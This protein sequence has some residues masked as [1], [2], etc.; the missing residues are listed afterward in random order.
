VRLPRSVD[1]RSVVAVARF[2]IVG[3]NPWPDRQSRIEAL[4]PCP[5]L[6]RPDY[7]KLYHYDPDDRER[8]SLG[9][10]PVLRPGERYRLTFV[11][12]AMASPNA[13]VARKQRGFSRVLVAVDP[14]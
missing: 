13:P 12:G 11:R 3:E 7:A 8:D 5:E 14:R 1:L 9:H 6:S 4:V 2:E 10:A